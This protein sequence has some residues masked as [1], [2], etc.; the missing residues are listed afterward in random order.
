LSLFAPVVIRNAELGIK[1]LRC[2]PWVNTGD[3]EV[4]EGDQGDDEEFD[5][6]DEGLDEDK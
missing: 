6:I 3:H 4:D 5:E 1:R 2:L